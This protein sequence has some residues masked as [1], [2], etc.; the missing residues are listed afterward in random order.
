M[1]K[2]EREKTAI[3]HHVPDMCPHSD[4]ILKIG[5]IKDFRIV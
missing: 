2:R 3:S 4:I 1:T 5:F